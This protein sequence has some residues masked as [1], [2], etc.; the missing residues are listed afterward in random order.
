MRAIGLA[1]LIV[2]GSVVA[3]LAQ[4]AAAGNPVKGRQYAASA[5]ADCHSLE[6]PSPGGAN[7][8]NQTGKAP[9]FSAIAAT[10][11]M[12]E[13]ALNAFFRQPHPTMPTLLVLPEDARD[14]IAYILSLKR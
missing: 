12:T 1:A 5:C 9:S 14:V 2:V 6:L 13:L 8:P 11:G 10:P 3:A 4:Q 7:T